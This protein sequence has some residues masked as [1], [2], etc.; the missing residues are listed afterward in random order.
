[1]RRSFALPYLQW[2]EANSIVSAAPAA[3]PLWAIETR[4]EPSKGGQLIPGAQ[5]R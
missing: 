3:I 1:M 2:K 5:I 4:C